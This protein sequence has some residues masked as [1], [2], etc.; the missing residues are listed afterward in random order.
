LISVGND[1]I[2]LKKIDAARTKQARF[3]TKFLTQEEVDLYDEKISNILPFEHFAWLLWSIKESVYKCHKRNNTQLVFSPKKIIVQQVDLPKGQP[4]GV[5]DGNKIE[6]NGF[7][8]VRTFGCTAICEGIYF[9]S[10]SLV[11]NE[12]IH[13]VA[14]NGDGFMQI[15]WGITCIESGDYAG[16]HRT[17]RDFARN[18]LQQLFPSS[19][20]LITK[21]TE[22]IPLA[23]IEDPERNLPLSFSHHEQFV[24]YCFISEGQILETTS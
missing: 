1:I 9:N 14:T 8:S 18:R 24:G 7:D 4:V 20:L 13:S 6:A 21:D 2:S 10:R 17:V 15:Q 11:N 16:Q 12:F 5:F 3:Y 19:T 22:G 23:T